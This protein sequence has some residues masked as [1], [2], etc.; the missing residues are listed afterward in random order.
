MNCL[1][2]HDD[3]MPDITWLNFWNPFYEPGKIC[4]TCKEGFPI[5]VDHVCPMCSRPSKN[6]EVCGDCQRWSNSEAFQGALERNVSVFSYTPIMKDMMAKWKYRGDYELIHMFSEDVRKKFKEAFG[7]SK[8]TLVPIPLSS[9]RE[10]ERG[11]NQAKAIAMLLKRPIESVLTRVQDEKQSK[12]T[13]QERME[14]EN[15]FQL[16]KEVKGE[17]ILIDDI[18]TTGM[19]LHWAAELL[20]KGGSTKIQS[21]TLIRS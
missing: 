5:I 8:A 2:C 14:A 9:S 7:K 11:F 19:T 16:V 12:K 20:K 17:I 10:K 18:Y 3:I 15:P 1:W 13:R 4:T 21:F 6:E